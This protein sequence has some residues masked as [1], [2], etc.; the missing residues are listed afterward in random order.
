LASEIFLN[1]QQDSCHKTDKLS[2]STT[3]VEYDFQI[4][5]YNRITLSTVEYVCLCCTNLQNK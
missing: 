3:T 1:K 2:T 4:D 5:G